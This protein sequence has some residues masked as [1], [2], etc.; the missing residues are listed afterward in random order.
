MSSALAT[1]Q[2][3]FEQIKSMA[4]RASHRHHG[5]IIPPPSSNDDLRV[6]SVRSLPDGS[7]AADMIDQ[8]SPAVSEEVLL[9]IQLMHGHFD[10]CLWFL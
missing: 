6:N 9:A 10:V 5:S 1:V 4:M 2:H 3:G 8:N 7:S